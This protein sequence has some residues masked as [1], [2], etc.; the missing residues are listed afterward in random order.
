MLLSVTM[1][2]SSFQLILLM[3]RYV[4]G[5][6]PYNFKYTV[7]SSDNACKDKSTDSVIERVVL[8]LAYLTEMYSV[9]YLLSDLN[10][11]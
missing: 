8:S 4:Q 9:P 2:T 6:S 11:Y 5:A 3:Y 7:I 1:F 10:S